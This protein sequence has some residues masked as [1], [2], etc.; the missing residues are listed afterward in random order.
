VAAGFG[1]RSQ[2]LRN[3]AADPF[4]RV[5]VGWR[6]PVDATAVR[7]P[8]AESALAMVTYARD[9]QWA[10]RILLRLSGLPGDRSTDDYA[11]VGASHI[12]FIRIAPPLPGHDHT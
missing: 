12:L 11:A 9:H 8:R 7:L 5:Q 3:I 6:R 2:W 4:V 1:P 10:A